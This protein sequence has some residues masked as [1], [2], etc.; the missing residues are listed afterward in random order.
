MEFSKT[1]ISTTRD[2]PAE[3][4]IPSHRLMLRAGIIRK[5]MSGVYNYLPV[6]WRALHKTIDIVR[7]EMNR[8]GAV[9]IL[10]PVLQPAELWKES[11]RYDNFGPLMCKF[12]DRTGKTNVLGPTHEEVVTDIVRNSVS[13]YKQLPFTLYQIQ[14]KFRDELRPRFGVLRSREFIMKDAYSFDFDEAGLNKSYEAM[15]EAYK[16]I[17]A[18][19][20]LRISIV[21]ADTGLMGGSGSHE[22]MVPSE[23]GEDSLVICNKCGYAAN[24]EKAES[25]ILQQNVVTTETRTINPIEQV[26]TPNMSTV[27]QICSFFKILPSQILKTIII[28]VE[29]DGKRSFVAACVRGDYELNLAK[30]ARA[31]KATNVELATPEEIEDVTGAPVGFS[32]PVGLKIPIVADLMLEGSQNMVA[33]ANKKDYHSLGICVFRDFKPQFFADLR[34]VREGDSC[35]RCMARLSFHKGIEVGHVF[36]LGTKYSEKLKATYLDKDGQAR[37]IIMGCYG[38][39]VNRIVASAI[40][41]NNDQRGIIWPKEI[42]PFH[43]YIVPTNVEDANILPTARQIH[44]RLEANGVECVIDDRKVAPGVK[45]NDADLL[46]FPVRITVGKK[47]AQSKTVDVRTRMWDADTAV[48]VDSVVEKTKEV[49]KEYKP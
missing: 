18:R 42:T 7:E 19:C 21:E 47:L 23:A 34:M 8:A 2:D 3:A 12:E 24:A 48:T 44:D 6:G 11:G 46:G 43:A 36:K 40:E 49:L 35:S 14:V 32:G 26:E 16:R 30:L 38:I 17:F 13:S 41:V 27:Q 25:V 33:G 10:M 28:R 1:L 39:G 29:A 4:E 15:Y 31:I 45:F 20:G 37:P 22:F 5:L 9:E